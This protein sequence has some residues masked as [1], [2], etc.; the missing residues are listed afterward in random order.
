MAVD[1]PPEVQVDEKEIA[2]HQLDSLSLL[3]YTFLLTITVLT[4]WMF[5]HRR[6]R[7]LHETGLALFY[8][9]II[10]AIV[11]YGVN[12]FEDNTIMRVKPVHKND[13]KNGT[14]D[15]LWLEVTESHKHPML[16]NRT[17][18]Y[19]FKGEVRDADSPFDQKTTFDPE[20]FFN[21]LLPPI[22]FHAGYSM[23][24][25]FFFRNIGAILTFAF[26]GTTISTFTVAGIMYGVTRL[27]SHLSTTFTFLDTLRF[28][29][30]ISATDPVTI[31]AIFTDLNV[32]V[33][34]YA[35]V[36]GESVLNDAVAMVITRT[37][38]DYEESA[39]LT[40]ETS[41]GYSIFFSSL[42][43]FIGIFSASFIL[44]GVMG[45]L[46]AALT[47]FTQ[48]RNYP[49]LEST[50]F[51]LMSYSTFLMAE[52]LDLTGIVAVL[53][54][55]ICQ[56][57]Y[58]YNNLSSESRIVTKQFFGLLNFMAENF[59]FSYVGV[60]MFTFSK[61]KFDAAFITGSFLAIIV[62]RAVN[63][64]PLSFLLNLGRKS[65]ITWNLQHMLFL[66]GLRGAIAFA[67]AI[68]NTLTDARQMILTATLVIV[69]VTVVICGGSTLSLM[70][71]FNIPLGVEDEEE[72]NLPSSSN[73]SPRHTYNSMSEPPVPAGSTPADKSKAAAAWS[74]FDAKYMKP[75]LTHSNPTLMET[76]PDCCNSMARVFTST[77]QLKNHPSMMDA[78][79]RQDSTDTTVG[80]PEEPQGGSDAEA[81]ITVSVEKQQADNGSPALNNN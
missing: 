4:I 68:R 3:L 50:L 55:G 73:G 22:I 49:Q 70:T 15:V 58:T 53:S 32:D 31:L 18:A 64:Y 61:H 75:L 69:M 77:Q 66:S 27:F 20:I 54:C 71:W 14:P 36:F 51:V 7:Y 41:S 59:I 9:L 48:I 43:E 60:S 46:T 19:T 40:T 79:A 12:G 16:L 10:G 81:I 45:C 63:I 74:G 56:A 80:S 1:L 67:L 35:M 44:G 76:L 13:L 5:K 42:G 2:L 72:K 6:I 30:L 26:V 38:E 21:I 37:I 33:N 65:K 23:K 11:K 78:T 25:R 28:G 52:T 24:K 57:H 8:G 62:G 34:L 47:K 29:A 39:R 17:L